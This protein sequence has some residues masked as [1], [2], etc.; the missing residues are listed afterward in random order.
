MGA[1]L[2]MNEEGRSTQ[3]GCFLDVALNYPIYAD[4]HTFNDVTQRRL[5]GYRRWNEV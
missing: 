4:V 5:D 2:A 1:P 3:S